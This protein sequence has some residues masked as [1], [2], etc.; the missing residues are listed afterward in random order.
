MDEL[1]RTDIRTYGRLTEMSTKA[2]GRSANLR[3]LIAKAAKQRSN[4][5]LYTLCRPDETMP[6]GLTEMSMK[7]EARNANPR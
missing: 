3:G 7:G 1:A 5:E 2:E 6:D 4:Q